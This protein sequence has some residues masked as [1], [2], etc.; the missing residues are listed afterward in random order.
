MKKIDILQKLYLSAGGRNV[1]SFS[2]AGSPIFFFIYSLAVTTVALIYGFL[3]F[4]MPAAIRSISLDLPLTS[5]SY[6]LFSYIAGNYYS[7]LCRGLIGMLIFSFLVTLLAIRDKRFSLHIIARVVAVEG[8][9][10]CMVC[11]PL[12]MPGALMLRLMFLAIAL[13]SYEI[14]RRP[15]LKM[16]WTSPCHLTMLMLSMSGIILLGGYLHLGVTVW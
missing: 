1:K 7:Q 8:S 6:D 10:L 14:Y 12:L 15:L 13:V 3:I 9:L 4:Y 5:I 11:I 16:D 2:L